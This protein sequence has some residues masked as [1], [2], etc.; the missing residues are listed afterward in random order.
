MPTAQPTATTRQ[1]GPRS[2]LL[3]ILES[4]PKPLRPLL[5]MLIVWI[6]ALGIPMLFYLIGQICSTG[7][8]SG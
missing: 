7:S 4:A 1:A 2:L 8:L 5:I 6:P 3:L